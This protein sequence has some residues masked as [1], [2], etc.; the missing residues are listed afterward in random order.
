M[1]ENLAKP[2]VPQLS[3]EDKEALEAPFSEEEL[4]KALGQLNTNKAPGSDGLPPEF[5][6]KFWHLIAPY[7]L[8]SLQSS[9]LY[10][11]KMWI[12]VI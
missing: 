2:D 7:Y 12:N 9:L 8:D 4:R 1:E 5:Y 3:E 11:K 6:G 10:L